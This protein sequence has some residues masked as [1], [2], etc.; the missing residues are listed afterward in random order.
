MGEGEGFGNVV[1]ESDGWCV[2][3]KTRAPERRPCKLR[4]CGIRADVGLEE[5]GGNEGREGGARACSEQSDQ[6]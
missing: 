1:K 5:Q 4:L 3:S 2:D 6:R